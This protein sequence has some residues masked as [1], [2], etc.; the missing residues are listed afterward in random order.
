MGL[1]TAGFTAAIAVLRMEDN[2]QKPEFGP[3]LVNG[4]TG[5]VGMYAALIAGLMGAEVTVVGSS[6]KADFLDQLGKNRIGVHR[7]SV[8]AVLGKHH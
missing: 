7:Q 8:Q 4:A 2:G 3:I 5:G 1:G 6:R